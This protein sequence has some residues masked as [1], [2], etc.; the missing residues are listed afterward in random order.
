MSYKYDGI[1]VFL[2]QAQLDHGAQRS[3][4]HNRSLEDSLVVFIG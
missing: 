4:E 3:Q 1:A 2:S